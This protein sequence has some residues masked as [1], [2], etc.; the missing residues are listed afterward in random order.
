M[1]PRYKVGDKVTIKSWEE[2]KAT[3]DDSNDYKKEPIAFAS[4]MHK[5][6]G[7]TYKITN[8]ITAKKY[9][10][11]LL[12]NWWYVED[13]I[14]PKEVKSEFS[15]KHLIFFM[16]L[17]LLSGNRP[18]K[19]I[20]KDRV[21]FK[22]EKGFNWY[23]FN[24]ELSMIDISSPLPNW[25]IFTSD[26][27]FA[28]LILTRLYEYPISQIDLDVFTKS[29]HYIID[30]IDWSNTPEGYDFWDAK[31]VYYKYHSNTDSKTLK[32]SNKTENHEIK[33]QRKKSTIIRG[34]VPE[35]SI[36]R[37]RK[38]KVTITVGYLSNSICIGG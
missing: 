25:P 37:G 2:I 30:S 7:K 9:P 36:T 26:I 27:D 14:K 5:D 29:I 38:R 8:I 34:T 32:Q 18:D 21:P 11:Y 1:E 15:E 35:G 10:R 16:C 3:L 6:L 12:N 24:E 20:F 13:W 33:L 22:D 31:W 23:E 17:Q 4:A 28:E 19:S